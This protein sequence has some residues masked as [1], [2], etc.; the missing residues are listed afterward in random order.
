MTSTYTVNKSEE[1]QNRTVWSGLHGNT[2]AF[3]IVQL[4]ANNR[5]KTTLVV[6]KDS[7]SEERIFNAL[8][9]LAPRDLAG[10]IIRFP[11]WETLPYDMFSPHQDIISERLS[12]LY[13]LVSKFEGILVMS[14][15]TLMQRTAPIEYIAGSSFSFEIGDKPNRFPVTFEFD[16]GQAR[17]HPLVRF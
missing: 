11:G 6:T 8:L 15:H 7:A 17:P 3:E 12:S 4:A 10:S 1:S 9:F 16:G 5:D 14:A 13:K 2:D